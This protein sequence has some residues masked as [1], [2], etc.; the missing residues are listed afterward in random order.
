MTCHLCHEIITASH[1][2]EHHHPI[3]KSNGGTVTNPTHKDCHRGFHSSQ[4]DFKE[5]GRIGGKLTALTRV[6]AFNLK[7]IKDDPAFDLDRKFY[8]SFYAR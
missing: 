5:W 1:Q 2:V 7:S 4:G 3:Y 6:W 8:K